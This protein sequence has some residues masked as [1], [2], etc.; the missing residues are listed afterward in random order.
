[1]VQLKAK[2]TSADDVNKKA[3]CE[4][5]RILAFHQQTD[6]MGDMPYSEAMKGIDGLKP[7]YDTQKSI[8][9]AMLSEL[10]TALKSM[11]PSKS[12]VFGAADPYFKGDVTKWKKFGYTLQ[13]TFMIKNF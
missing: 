7:K 2:L 11:D 8:Y 9:A 13:E 12:N 6:L 10:E 4:I 5:L 1:M 3:A